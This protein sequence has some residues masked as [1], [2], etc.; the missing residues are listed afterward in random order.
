MSADSTWRPQPRHQR[1]L[2]DA[3]IHLGATGLAVLA[4]EM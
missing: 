1:L 4:L 2:L 3:D